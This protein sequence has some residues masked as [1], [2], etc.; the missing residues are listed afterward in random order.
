[1]ATPA[2]AVQHHEVV[3]AQEQDDGTSGDPHAAIHPDGHLTRGR[4]IRPPGP[5]SPGQ[6]DTLGARLGRHSAERLRAVGVT[7]DPWLFILVTVAAD[8]SVW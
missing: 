4:S 6:H 2:A 3:G 1:M 8:R 7:M 5:P